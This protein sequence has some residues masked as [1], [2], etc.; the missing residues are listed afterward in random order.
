[1]RHVLVTGAAGF[2]GAKISEML[3]DGGDE[4]T[5]VDILNDIYD[6]RLKEYR[7]KKLTDRDGFRFSRTDITDFE[8]LDKLFSENRF[9]AVVNMAAIPGVRLSMQD[10]WLYL[11][12]NTGGT[13]NLLE[14]AHRH[15]VKKFIEA[16]TSSIYGE[17]A[18]YPTDETASSDRPL[19][20]YSASKKGAEAEC[21]AYHYLYDIDV[22][23]FRFFTVYGPAG[24]P[25]MAIYRFIRW[26]TEGEP[27]LLNGDG[28]QTRG[29]TYVDDIARGCI[30]GLKN[31]GFEVMNL[32]GHES[33]SINDLIRKL[34]G[35]IGKPA[36]VEHRPVVKADMLANLADISKARKLLNWDPQV[37]LDEGLR[38]SVEWYLQEREFLKGIRI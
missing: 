1:M 8:S 27:I 26:I 28:N 36:A 12:V 22:T 34:E 38:R 33:I 16:S 19:Q 3:L 5:G 4:V 13:L 25:D 18:P 30:L 37:D 2:I 11:R 20:P 23:I 9:D 14:C 10:P 15:D 35:M 32:G 21:H 6:C 7:L 29:F 31:V 17:N 24:R